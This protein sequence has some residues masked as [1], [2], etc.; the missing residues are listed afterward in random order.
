M[1]RR[2]VDFLQLQRCLLRG[3]ITEG[4]YVPTSSATGYWR[5]NVEATV[6]GDPLRVVVE[7]PDNPPGVLVITVI[8]LR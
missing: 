1:R 3:E 7:L 2:H 5:C 6:N 8:R 4:P